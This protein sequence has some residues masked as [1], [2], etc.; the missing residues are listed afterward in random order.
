ME[1]VAIPSILDN[2]TNFQVFQDDQHIL[3]FVLSNQIF[4]G[5]I[6]DTEPEEDKERGDPDQKEEEMIGDNGIWNLKA[7]TIP[8]GMVE[9]KRMFDNDESTKIRRPPPERGSDECVLVNLVI[10]EDPRMV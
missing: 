3:E 2:I 1:L 9:L 6:I 8:K 4:E 5:Q 10:S 7:N